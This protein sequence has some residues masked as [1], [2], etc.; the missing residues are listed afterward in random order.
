MV[1]GAASCRLHIDDRPEV[2]EQ[3]ARPGRSSHLSYHFQMAI[4]LDFEGTAVLDTFFVS[5]VHALMSASCCHHDE[6]HVPLE[7]PGQ[8]WLDSEAALPT[9]ACRCLLAE[10]LSKKAC[11]S[12]S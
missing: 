6:D 2:R 4:G 7:Q 5:V 9:I 10:T 3:A 11:E 1:S 8:R 12:I